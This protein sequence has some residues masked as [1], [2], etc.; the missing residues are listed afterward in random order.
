MSEP[1]VTLT[2]SIARRIGEPVN[3]VNFLSSVS[4]RD[5]LSSALIHR[6]TT[7]ETMIRKM[8]VLHDLTPQLAELDRVIAGLD[9]VINTL[10]EE[11][12]RDAVRS[13]LS[14]LQGKRDSLAGLI[15]HAQ[16]EL[17]HATDRKNN[18]ESIIEHTIID[19]GN[20]SSVR[21]VVAGINED[22]DRRMGAAS[23]RSPYFGPRYYIPTEESINRAF[24]GVL[25]SAKDRIFRDMAILSD[26][27]AHF[28]NIMGGNLDR[29]RHAAVQLRYGSVRGG[30]VSSDYSQGRIS[31][32]V[33]VDFYYYKQGQ[34]EACSTLREIPASEPQLDLALNAQAEAERPGDSWD[35]SRRPYSSFRAAI[36]EWLGTLTG[37]D[38][39]YR[40]NN[41]E[42][43]EE[44]VT[45]QSN[46]MQ[47]PRQLPIHIGGIGWLPNNI[48]VCSIIDLRSDGLPVRTEVRLL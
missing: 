1:Q 5:G 47:L 10:P 43:T 28:F 3:T 34:A 6:A 29:G 4:E 44:D 20:L 30:T 16:R 23:E 15:R 25:G 37:I 32:R 19:N 42:I 12:Q 41:H 35:Y 26:K 46:R 21:A 39:I 24:D 7:V 2:Q 38:G 45:A 31:P 13:G 33:G 40:G 14:Q 27:N 36:N 17:L 11:A 48:S 9:E 22:D 18:I 8:E